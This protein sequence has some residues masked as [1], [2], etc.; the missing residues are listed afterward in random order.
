MNKYLKFLCSFDYNTHA[1]LY[2]CDE[3]DPFT[4][5]VKD[6]SI[7]LSTY[8]T[9]QKMRAAVSHKFGREFGYGTQVWT[10]RPLSPGKFTGNPSLSTVVSQYMVSLR[11]RK[12]SVFRH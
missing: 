11:R 3:V 5:K 2:R 10:E 12:V 6:P 7:A 8:A 1:G 9:A 4:N